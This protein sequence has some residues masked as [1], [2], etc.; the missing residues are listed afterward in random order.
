MVKITICPHFIIDLPQ[1]ATPQDIEAN[2]MQP[3]ISCLDEA[4]ERNIN[5][6]LSYELVA[7]YENGFPW[8]RMDNTDWKGYLLDW[9]ASIRSKLLNISKLKS[10]PSTNRETVVCNQ[11][12]DQVNGLFEA[13]LLALHSSGMPSGMYPEGVIYKSTCGTNSLLT[14]FHRI[15]APSCFDK[16]EH[17]WLRIY[18]QPLPPKG[19]FPFIPPFNWNHSA[20]PI[21]RNN[22]SN[23]GYL[24]AHG[25]EWEWDTLHDDHWD[26]QHSN[27]TNDYTNVNVDGSLR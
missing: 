22:F 6:Y 7:L 1:D 2:Y 27:R 17:P 25:N 15:E 4:N 11:L 19:E 10:I 18:N 16:V 12:S 8:D 20:I 3:L 14:G 21:R 26:V 9:D 23:Y 24:D 13:L 5:I